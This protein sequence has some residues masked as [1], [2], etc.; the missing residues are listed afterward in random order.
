M[1]YDIESSLGCSHCVSVCSFAVCKPDPVCV[2][3]SAYMCLYGADLYVWCSTRRCLTLHWGAFTP[4]GV[5][6]GVQQG[7]VMT[8]NQHPSLARGMHGCF[9]SAQVGE[10]RVRLTVASLLTGGPPLDFHNVLIMSFTDFWSAA[11]GNNKAFAVGIVN[12]ISISRS[13]EQH[14]SMC[15]GQFKGWCLLVWLA[16]PSWFASFALNKTEPSA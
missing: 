6:S 8:F 13:M 2:C 9:P 3:A 14:G 11:K 10:S 7:A 15:C 5:G 1:A 4:L 12:S 16:V